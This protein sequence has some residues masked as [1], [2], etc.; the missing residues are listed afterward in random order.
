[1]LTMIYNS[2]ELMNNYI[3]KSNSFHGERERERESVCVCVCVM[4]SENGTSLHY[5]RYTTIYT[6]IIWGYFIN[7]KRCSSMYRLLA[8]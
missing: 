5:R 4:I 1:M 7:L 2:L 6:R 3:T 8:V